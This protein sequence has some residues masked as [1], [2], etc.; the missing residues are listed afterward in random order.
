MFLLCICI[1]NALPGA[2][3]L[4]PFWDPFL[5]YGVLFSIFFAALVQTVR[6]RKKNSSDTSFY[7][8]LMAL[9]FYFMTI[10]VSLLKTL[11]V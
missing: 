6:H 2:E 1:F 5:S 9:G 7:L 8:K 10:A 3:D 4:A 11:F